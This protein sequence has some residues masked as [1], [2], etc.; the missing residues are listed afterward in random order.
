MKTIIGI[1]GACGRVGQRL[2]ALAREDKDLELGAALD[3]AS[4]PCQGRDAGEV[5]GVGK[6][7]VPV[8][9]DVPLG[10]RLDAVI[11]FSSPEGTMTV[12]PVCVE[13]RIPLVVATTGHTAAQK[14]EI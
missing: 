3:A 1:N 10:L 13:R 11:D 7:G 5:A 6:V 9:A 2:V 14:K 4:H 12:L 8:R